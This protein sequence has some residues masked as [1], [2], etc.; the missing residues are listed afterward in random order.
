M[1]EKKEKERENFMYFW[2]R[3]KKKKTVKKYKKFW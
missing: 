3:R 2:V 1:R